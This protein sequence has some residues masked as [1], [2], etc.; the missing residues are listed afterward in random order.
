MGNVSR[1]AAGMPRETYEVER[2]KLCAALA[3]RLRHAGGKHPFFAGDGAQALAVIQDKVDEL[4][5]AVQGEGRRKP[6]EAL[7]VMAVAAR[8]RLGEHLSGGRR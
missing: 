3:G 1:D 4:K 5:K 8:V 7:D 2:Q 6:D